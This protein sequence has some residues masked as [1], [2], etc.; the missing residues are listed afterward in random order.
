M[1]DAI[2]LEAIER[3]TEEAESKKMDISKT[4]NRFIDPYQLKKDVSFSENNLDDAMSQQASLYAYYASQSAKAQLQCDRA[5]HSMEIAEAKIYHEYRG[6]HTGEKTTE[7][8]LSKLVMIDKRYIAA[9]KRYND[10]KMIATL[11][12]EAT[13]SLR[14]RRDVLT[15]V[16]KH[17]LEQNKGELF[18]KGRD[19]A[20]A[21]KKQAVLDKLSSR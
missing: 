4:L 19:G 3:A 13:E 14:H 6:K 8:Y 15:Q 11:C 21:D 20:V 1:T 12:K 10:A 7:S 17:K 16:S 5:K 9:V 18:L 2:D